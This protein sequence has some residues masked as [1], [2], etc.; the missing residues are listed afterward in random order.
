M[1][2]AWV[3]RTGQKGIPDWIVPPLS[4]L[5]AFVIGGILLL[6]WGADP[7][8][9]F[10]GMLVGALGD[11]YAVTEV[12]VRATPLIFCGLAV[13]IAGKMSA[14]NI[15]AEG[16][17]MM[18]GTAAAGLALYV[19]PGFPGWACIPLLVLG[20]MAGGALWGAVPDC[21]GPSGGSTRSFRR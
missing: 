20:A 8:G 4:V 2:F 15:G 16:Q 18:G 19:L 17:F 7:V 6:I 3:K 10:K 5:F 14:W 1:G 12:L 11:W 9:V 13:G 21:F